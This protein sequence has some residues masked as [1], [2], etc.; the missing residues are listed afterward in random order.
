MIE[1]VVKWGERVLDVLEIHHP[2][3]LLAD[4]P[5]DV[6]L[7]PV[8]VAMQAGALVPIGDVCE[9]VGCLEGELAEDLHHAIPRYLWVCR[10]SRHWGW[11]RQYSTASRVFLSRSG[12]SIGCSNNRGNPRPSNISGLAPSCG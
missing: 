11:D 9:A 2:A 7:N 12:P 4:R 5:V 3:G 10:L 6:D 1:L 8:G